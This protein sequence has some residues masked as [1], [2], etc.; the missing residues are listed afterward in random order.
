MKPSGQPE[1]S[2]HQVRAHFVAQGSSLNR[3]AKSNGLSSDHVTKAVMGK[4]RGPKARQLLEHV[5]NTV[6]SQKA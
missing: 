5:L 3:W 6:R 2:I 1:F 4:R